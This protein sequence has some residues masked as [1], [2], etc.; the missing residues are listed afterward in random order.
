MSKRP[1]RP[2]ESDGGASEGVS[3]IT[4]N[5]VEYFSDR[6]YLNRG[7]G[8]PP[9][10][11]SDGCTC[12]ARA[13]P[14]LLDRERL[15][16]S[17]DLKAAIVASYT[18]APCHVIR[19]YPSLFGPDSVVPTLVLHGHK[20]LSERMREKRKASM[21]QDS[22][23]STAMMQVGQNDSKR[24]LADIKAENGTQNMHANESSDEDESSPRVKSET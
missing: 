11:P 13:P 24:T 22:S 4:V 12:G 18:V 15:V 9:V 8:D 17:L 10:T 14:P 3:S 21:S 20:G 19:E 2:W 23:H 5:G 16:A 6:F 1:S 7:V